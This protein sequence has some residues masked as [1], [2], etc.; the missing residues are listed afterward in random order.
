[1]DE[2]SKGERLII[3]FLGAGIVAAAFWLITILLGG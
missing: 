2:M 3:G 1:M